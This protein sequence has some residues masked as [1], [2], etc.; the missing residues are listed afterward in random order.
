RSAV[1]PVVLESA[2]ET[3]RVTADILYTLGQLLAAPATNSAV[4]RGVVSCSPPVGLERFPAKVMLQGT[5]FSTLADL[6]GHYEFHQ[7]PPGTYE[8]VALQPGGGLSR[9]S[10]NL[11]ASKTKICHF[12]LAAATTNLVRNGDF[13]LSWL[14]AG[15]PDCWYHTVNGWEGEVIPLKDGQRYR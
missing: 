10:V 5:S 14:R 6:S 9:S 1:R 4:L 3:S 11:A 8:V 15:A 13:Q 12:T 7:L 2:L